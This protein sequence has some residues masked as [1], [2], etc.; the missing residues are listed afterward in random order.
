MLAQPK[1]TGIWHDTYF[2]VAH[3]HMIMGWPA[4]SPVCTTY[5]WFP[6]MF[7]DRLMDERSQ[8]PFWLTLSRLC[9]IHADALPWH[10]DIR[11]GTRKS[12]ARPTTCKICFRYKGY[13]DFGDGASCGAAD[14]LFNLFRSMYTGSFPPE[15]WESTSLEWRFRSLANK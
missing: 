10:V 1:W 13:Y 4:S 5:F 6:K 7:A 3:F 2:V 15:S 14:F 8:D 9:H 11:A 12:S